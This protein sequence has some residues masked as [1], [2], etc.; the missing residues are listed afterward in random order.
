[1]RLLTKGVYYAKDDD[2]IHLFHDCAKYRGREQTRVKLV[3]HDELHQIAKVDKDTNE[4]SHII[5]FVCPFCDFKYG[6]DKNLNL[7]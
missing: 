3:L 2:G 4:E 5:Q 1:M 6:F 7:K